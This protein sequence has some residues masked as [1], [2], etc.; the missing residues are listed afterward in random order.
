MLYTIMLLQFGCVL[1]LKQ[2]TFEM[3]FSL[4][5]LL[6]P[7][8]LLHFFPSPITLLFSSLPHFFL[9]SPFLSLITPLVFF[10]FPFLPPFSLPFLTPLVFF[11]SLFLPPFSLPSLTPSLLPFVPS[12]PP[13][14][15]RPTV[16]QRHSTSQTKIRGSTSNLPARLAAQL[17]IHYQAAV[18]LAHQKYMQRTTSERNKTCYM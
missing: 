9:F 11:H 3:K 7:P 1:I 16:Q 2:V 18:H 8:F 12:S 5:S 13:S 15:L 14:F 4:F 17:G 6:T 10:H